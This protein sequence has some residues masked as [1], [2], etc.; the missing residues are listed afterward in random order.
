MDLLNK[1]QLNID[2]TSVKQSV[3]NI[4][5]NLNYFKSKEIL[6]NIFNLIDLTSLNVTDTFTEIYETT[7]KVNHFTEKFPEMPNVAAICVYPALVPVVKKYLTAEK[8]GI[9]SVAAGFPAS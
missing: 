4:L 6:K 7:E 8:V 2:E 3:A 5:N 9:A 1:Y